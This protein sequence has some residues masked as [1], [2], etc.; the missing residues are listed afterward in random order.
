MSSPNRPALHLPLRLPPPAREIPRPLTPAERM[1]RSL[2]ELA[3]R[4]LHEAAAEGRG[5]ETLDAWHVHLASGRTMR[6]KWIGT[7]GPFL[8]VVGMDDATAVLLAP[9]A[10]QVTIEPVAPDSEEQGFEIGFRAPDD[11]ET[12]ADPEP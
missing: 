5:P 11:P 7:Y 10:V 3:Q 2:R 6:I 4:L 9:E 1:H 8:R 12:P